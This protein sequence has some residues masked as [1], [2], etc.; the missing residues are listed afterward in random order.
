MNEDTLQKLGLSKPEALAYSY[1]LEN[2]ESS[3]GQMIKRLP[4][5][6]GNLY[7]VLRDLVFK[8]LAEE[9]KKNKVVVFR[10]THPS[11]ILYYLAKEGDDLEARKKLAEEIME[12]LKSKYS[13]NNNRP[14]VHY[15]EGK[16]GVKKVLEDSLKSKTEIYSY[17]DIESVEKYL[18]E[19]N[20]RYVKKREELKIKKKGIVLDTP[21]AR[22][23]LKDYHPTITETKLI[24]YEARPYQTVMQIYDG[25]ISYITLEEKIM[26]GVIIED[27][28]IYEMH[29]YM[30]E[31]L[32]SATPEFKP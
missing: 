18:S 12:E 13:L 27:P 31:Y 8:G 9:F 11:Q 26:I 19:I 15:F 17:A 21:F 7:N 3:V 28:H 22:E 4:I 6:R 23:F 30:F 29:K 24:G 5:K 1:L 32:W 20:K 2:G 16:D 10:A 25:K 14:G